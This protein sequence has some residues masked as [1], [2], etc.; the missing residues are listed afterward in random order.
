MHLNPLH[1]NNTFETLQSTTFM[2]PSKNLQFVK[3]SINTLHQ[4]APALYLQLWAHYLWVAGR[5]VQTQQ[6]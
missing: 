6:N 3:Y 1:V 4:I 5:N 2:G